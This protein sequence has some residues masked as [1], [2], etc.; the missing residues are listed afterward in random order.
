MPSTGRG[1]AG[2]AWEGLRALGSELEREIAG[3]VGFDEWTRMLYST[4]ASIYRIMPLGVVFPKTEDDVAATVALCTRYGF[5]MLPRGSG[6]SLAGQTVGEAVVI[7][8]SR[9]MDGVV[10]FEPE[11]GSIS[12]QPGIYLGSMNLKVAGSGL[13]FGPDPASAEHATVG[14]VMGNNGTGAHSILYGMAGDHLRSVSVILADGTRAVFEE[15]SWSEAHR[16]GGLPVPGTPGSTAGG[17][18]AAPPPVDL[19]SSIYREIIRIALDHADAIQEAFPKTW[20]RVGGYAL[21]AFQPEKPLN[22]S[23]LI[24][25]SEGTLCTIVEAELG[26]VPMPSGT[27]LAVLSFDSMLSSLATVPALLAEAPSAVELMDS[28]LM[29]L[30]RRHPDYSRRLTFV[31]GEPE[32]LLVVEVYG[33]SEAERA[34]HLERLERTARDAAEGP[35]GVLYFHDQAE[36]A[37]IWAVRN[38]GLGLLMSKRGDH[39]PIPF[40]EDTAVPPERLRDYIADVLRVLHDHETPAAFY[41]HAS[42]GCLHIRP[43]INL[44]DPPEVA[45]MASIS[46]AVLELVLQYSGAMAGEHGDGLAR[47]ALNPRIYGN[48]V[49]G[50]F[51]RVKDTFDPEGLMNPGKIVRA[52]AMTD[53]LRFGPDYRTAPVA[54]FFDFT[55]DGGFARAVEMCSGSGECLKI[56]TGTMCPSFMATKDEKNST[57]GRANSL[58]AVLSGA[59]SSKGME[60]E[61]LHETLDLCLEC[62]ACKTE[63][64]SQVDM[65]RLKTEFLAHYYKAR[66]TPLRVRLF[67]NIDRLNRIGSMTAPLSNWLAASY[68]VRWLLDRVLGVDMRHSM[69]TFH[70][71]TLEKQY[72]RSGRGPRASDVSE[73]ARG[74]VWLLPDTFT[75]YNDPGIGMAAVR[76]LRAAGYQVRLLPMPGGSSGRAMLSKG[77]IKQAREVARANLEVWAPLVAVGIPILGLEPS[78]LLTLRDEYPVLVPGK[79]ADAVAGAALILEEWLAGMEDELGPALQFRSPRDYDEAHLLVHGHCHLK[80]LVGMEPLLTV[81]GWLPQT[82]VKEVDS[83]CC[84]MAG[85]FG[86]EK[87]HYDL[88]MAIGAQRL[89]PAIEGL[90]GRGTVV[91]P[92]TSCRQQIRDA[93]GRE[94]LHPV[95]VLAGR[96]VN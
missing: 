24:A 53:S 83:G 48:E 61:R 3:E 79:A 7:D 72:A 40:V 12:V 73:P 57:R 45:K 92:G 75:N 34:A 74:T 5:P 33:E 54:T 43:L 81:L 31:E 66:G 59:V 27:S 29:G 71:R 84:G 76:L 46:E 2:S 65:T 11:S 68:P 32:A 47:S 70:R 85:S 35:F 21:D 23:R 42:A 82:E 93:T 49:Y 38:A 16:R 6:T 22:L 91:A 58:R 8:F 36:Q 60:D 41:A 95:E 55:A 39:K 52:P 37:N 90:N 64:P 20:R 62:K 96:L 44:K 1:D 19:H 88:S 15:V 18:R 77:M 63:C 10:R 9:Y 30:C 26:L 69:P 56:G 13:M 51:E 86:F 17:P 80:A 67:G 87:E 4:D 50:L 25:G 89:F 94:P 28:M 14:G 78:E